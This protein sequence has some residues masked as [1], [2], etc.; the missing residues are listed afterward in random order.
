MS[1]KMKSP[2]TCATA[3][4]VGAAIEQFRRDAQARYWGVA[5]R[6][7]AGHAVDRAESTAAVVEAGVDADQLAA[8]LE[9]L[10]QERDLARAAADLPKARA[11]VT[12]ARAAHQQVVEECGRTIAEAR[13]REAESGRTVAKA[14]EA[15]HRAEAAQRE[16]L[17]LR[18][19]LDARRNP[20]GLEQQQQQEA[21]GRERLA[22][23]GRLRSELAEQRRH[24][25]V[26]TDPS[27]RP[28][29]PQQ[30]AADVAALRQRVA[31]L[32]AELAEL[33]PEPAGV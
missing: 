11:R 14:T 27:L 2:P 12:E 17:S 26:A 4:D 30:H 28:W 24:L 18:R 7:A 13:Q 15:A 8:D 25:G 32:E 1:T 23:A 33:A 3:E 5:G 20:A 21:S 10:R 9:L 19:R 6:L 16:L 29:N 22:H 31:Q